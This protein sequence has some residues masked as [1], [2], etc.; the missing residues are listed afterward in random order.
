MT[1][2]LVLVGGGHAHLH[3]LREWA[4]RPMA[5]VD[6]VLVSPGAQQ[7]Y[8][9]MVPGYLEG[10]YDADELRIDLAALARCA[11]ARLVMAAAESVSAADRVV[12]AGGER[13]PFDICS[14]DVGS[15]MAGA[16]IPG[17]PEHAV[18]LRPMERAVQLRNRIDSLL[19][20]GGPPLS[21]AIVGAGAG[22]VE[23]AFALDARM[24]RSDRGGHVAIV[25]GAGEVLP[26]EPPRLRRRMMALLRERGIGLVLGRPV[27]RVEADGLV[28]ASGASVPAS[29]IVWAT[30]AAPPALFASSD[31]PRDDA[32]YLV[33]DRKLRALGGL[34]V[35]GAGDCVTIAKRPR[36]ARS[37]VQAVRQG[38]VLLHNLRAALG[39]G[40]ARRFHPRNVALALLST[41]D[42]RALARRGRFQGH[43]RWAWWLK[44]RIDRRFVARFAAPCDEKS[45]PAS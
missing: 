20:R 37:G 23:I 32:G 5:D 8:S 6:L 14:I 43:G 17:V 13:I 4:R 18:T 45:V 27:T 29:L 7:W 12:V 3:V 40:R 19:A 1:R 33:V 2:R 30:G 26:G 10:R 36:L 42:G 39:S 15:A 24:K 28:L 35:W 16:E 25:D 31:L 41:S 44:E 11:G 38:P 21:V 22:G 34:P 9:G